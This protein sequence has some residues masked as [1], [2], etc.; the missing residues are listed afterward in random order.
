M[1]EYGRFSPRVGQG[2]FQPWKPAGWWAAGITAP[3]TPRCRG[4]LERARMQALAMSRTARSM[5]SQLEI[6]LT[7]AMARYFGVPRFGGESNR[8]ISS[9]IFRARLSKQ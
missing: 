1:A 8:Y 3:M 5:I 9:L 7:M 6:S 4:P 2:S